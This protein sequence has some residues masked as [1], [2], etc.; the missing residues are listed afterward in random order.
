MENPFL[1]QDLM[2]KED[3]IYDEL[4]QTLK[5]L[6]LDTLLGLFNKMVGYLP[7]AEQQYYQDEV[8]FWSGAGAK[9][10]VI[11]AV[12]AAIPPEKR[13]PVLEFVTE[14][15]SLF[16]SVEENQEMEDYLSMGATEDGQTD[17]DYLKELWKPI[18]NFM[19]EWEGRVRLDPEQFTGTITFNVDVDNLEDEEADI[20]DMLEDAET[21]GWKVVVEDLPNEPLY[22]SVDTGIKASITADDGYGKYYSPGTKPWSEEDHPERK[23]LPD[24]WDRGERGE[25]TRDESTLIQPH[26]EKEF[27]DP[28]LFEKKD[29]FLP[30]MGAPVIIPNFS[31]MSEENKTAIMKDFKRDIVTALQSSPGSAQRTYVMEMVKNYLEEHNPDFHDA[32]SKEGMWSRSRYGFNIPILVNALFEGGITLEDAY[33]FWN[34]IVNHKILPGVNLDWTKLRHGGGVLGENIEDIFVTWLMSGDTSGADR[35]KEKWG[36]AFDLPGIQYER[37]P[38]EETPIGQRMAPKPQELEP[39]LQELKDKIKSHKMAMSYIMT[40]DLEL[41]RRAA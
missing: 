33:S 12:I 6:P 32:K 18:N 39:E 10:P 34:S 26:P 28:D 31:D 16:P 38:F 35:V 3:I 36:D 1:A 9:A 40:A 15:H 20:W 25:W 21:R 19:E 23:N 17:E 14:M 30:G 4:E 7:E 27:A 29:E 5:I 13:L 22:W 37:M 2:T 41:I 11:E 24:E 8:D